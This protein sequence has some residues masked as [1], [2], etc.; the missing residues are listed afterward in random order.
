MKREAIAL[1]GTFNSIEK[2]NVRLGIR[3][4]LEIGSTTE[5]TETFHFRSLQLIVTHLKVFI[6]LVLTRMYFASP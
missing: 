5:M 2:G 4:D 1:S 3:R 6:A